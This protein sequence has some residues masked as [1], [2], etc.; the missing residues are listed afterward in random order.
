MRANTHASK[1]ISK[2][3]LLS[4][5]EEYWLQSRTNP[6]AMVSKESLR[7]ITIEIPTGL[8]EIVPAYLASCLEELQQMTESLAVSDFNRLVTLGHNLKG[9][10]GSYGFP[11]L[12]RIGAA[13]EDSAKRRDPVTISTQLSQL[14]DYL[15][16]VELKGGQHPCKVAS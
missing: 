7:T 14:K 1:P 11:G 10:G 9:S 8:E 2:H 12:T 5:I 15:G 13:L 3:K 16:R 6:P 4:V